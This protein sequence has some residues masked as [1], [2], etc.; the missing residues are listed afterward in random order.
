MPPGRSDVYRNLTRRLWS[1]RVGGRVVGH[2]PAIV[3]ADVVLRASEA[4]RLRCLRTGARDVHAWATGTV[5][6]GD[7]PPS[8][9]R[10]RYGLWCPGFRTNGLLVTRAAQVWFEADGSAW[11]V[12]GWDAESLDFQ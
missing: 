1:V 2:V 11:C 4:G 12:G 7:R 8:A 10:L 5:A 6:E 9:Q 3:L